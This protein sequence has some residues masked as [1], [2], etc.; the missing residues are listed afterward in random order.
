MRFRSRMQPE[1]SKFGIGPYGCDAARHS[2]LI[3]PSDNSSRV[4]SSDNLSS[5]TAAHYTLT[6]HGAKLVQ[7]DI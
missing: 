3:G 2:T 4:Q 1:T 6:K 5:A 7:H